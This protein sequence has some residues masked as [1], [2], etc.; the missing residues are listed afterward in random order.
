MP[1]G[2]RQ[3]AVS[4]GVAVAVDVPVGAEHRPETRATEHCDEQRYPEGDAQ[5]RTGE[6]QG[7]ADDGE[8]DDEPDGGASDE[9]GGEAG[10]GLRFD[11]GHVIEGMAR[12]CRAE[13]A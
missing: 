11:D 12:P 6:Q 3:Q 10:R 8:D 5:V 7:R 2:V 13:N 9:R 1:L 4:D